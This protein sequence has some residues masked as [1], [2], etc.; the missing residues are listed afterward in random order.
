MKYYRFKMQVG[1]LNILSILMIIP[2]FLIFYLFF[3]KYEMPMSF[4]I[5]FIIWMFL[6]ELLHG[7]A[8]MLFKEVDNKKISY[9]IKL[10]SGIFYC[11]CKQPVRRKVILTS[12]IC[13]LFFIGII[14]FV[15]AVIFNLKTLAL[16]SMFNVCGCI[17]DI[18]MFIMFMCMKDVWYMDLDDCESFLVLTKDD[19]SNKKFIG[20]KLAESGDY[21]DEIAP[22]DFQQF[23][24]SN[25]SKILLVIIFLLFIISLCL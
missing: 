25:F 6:H 2:T 7:L 17:G 11:M 12:L 20:L 3:G 22:K 8:F 24:C 23:H 14:T 16:L 4:T 13:P 18:L 10:E 5:Y 21:T 19:I 9:G 15:I 1:L